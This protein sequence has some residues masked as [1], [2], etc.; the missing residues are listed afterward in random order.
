MPPRFVL[1]RTADGVM[2][3]VR[4]DVPNDIAAELESLAANEPLLSAPDEPPIATD[5]Y[6]ELLAPV[7]RVGGGP[8]YSFPPGGEHDA[9]IIEVTAERVYLVPDELSGSEGLDDGRD[10]PCFSLVIGEK[11]VSVCRTSRNVDGVVQ[12]GV[13]TLE[14][15]RGLGFGSRVVR[16]WG[17]AAR[18]RGSE[19]IY[20]TWLSNS[21]SRALATKAG[22]LLQGTDF[23]VF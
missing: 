20:S 6:K 3:R 15:W 18:D 17:R 1:V 22:L 12:A 2:S 14:E 9:E 10:M 16:A 7:E 13:Q 11:A 19:A 8:F 23:N 5:S 21:A 4:F